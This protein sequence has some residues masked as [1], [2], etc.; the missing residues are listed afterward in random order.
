MDPFTL[1]DRLE[2]YWDEWH[3]TFDHEM[4]ASRS[5]STTTDPLGGVERNARRMLEVFDEWKPPRSDALDQEW[6]AK[7]AT[8]QPDW[9]IG[10]NGFTQGTYEP[11][12][13]YTWTPHSIRT[14][15]RS[16]VERILKTRW[17][18]PQLTGAIY[19]QIRHAFVRAMERRNVEVDESIKPMA[20]LQDVSSL[21]VLGDGVHVSEER[22]QLIWDS[23]AL[24]SYGFLAR[25]NRTLVPVPFD[26]ADIAIEDRGSTS[27]SNGLRDYISEW[28]SGYAPDISFDDGNMWKCAKFN[29][30]I[31]GFA[32]G[33]IRDASRHVD[34]VKVGG[35]AV[36]GNYQRRGIGKKILDVFERSLPDY[37]RRLTAEAV[38]SSLPFWVSQGF[39]DKESSR[40]YGNCHSVEKTLSER[41]PS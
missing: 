14:C 25:A 26:D 8:V 2:A 40:R 28:C 20:G 30:R 17:D 23:L 18:H 7:L 31:I 16:R 32:T 13:D 5:H 35:L 33:Y 11:E 3:M 10:T 29:E 24:I 34:F 39:R 38:V 4:I 21:V 27:F 41:M 22:E 12:K 37:V 36:N 1:S 6:Q 19:A 15:I 9:K